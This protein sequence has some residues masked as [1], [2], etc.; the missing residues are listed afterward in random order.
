MRLIGW[1]IALACS[2]ANTPAL[3]QPRGRYARP[4]LEQCSRDA[5]GRIC[6]EPQPA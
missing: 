6:E 1:A 3:A 2:W 4:G 5:C